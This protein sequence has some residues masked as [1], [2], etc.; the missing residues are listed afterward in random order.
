MTCRQDVTVGATHDVHT[1]TPGRK[2][3]I[4]P[5][6]LREDL[7]EGLRRLPT[8]D[9]GALVYRSAEQARPT[10]SANPVCSGE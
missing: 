1:S 7:L 6:I 3:L 2:T 8:D 4:M 10:N 5:D 9:N